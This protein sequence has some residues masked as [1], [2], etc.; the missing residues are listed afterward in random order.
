MSLSS[1]YFVA[2]LIEN[3]AIQSEYFGRYFSGFFRLRSWKN[4][5]VMGKMPNTPVAPDLI[6]AR[7]LKKYAYLL[8]VHM[9]YMYLD[10][11]TWGGGRFGDW[12]MGTGGSCGPVSLRNNLLKRFREQSQDAC[13]NL[14]GVRKKLLIEI[15][16][17]DNFTKEQ[18]VV[19]A[20]SSIHEDAQCRP[21]PTRSDLK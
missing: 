17:S 16:M 12:E 7:G 18:V 4:S 5:F 20:A 21:F 11:W 10:K 8:T 1:A 2:S 14:H 19:A 15:K 13:R 6:S 3:P 9:L